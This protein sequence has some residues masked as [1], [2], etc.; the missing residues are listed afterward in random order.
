MAQGVNLNRNN[1]SVIAHRYSALSEKVGL[2]LLPLVGLTAGWL[3]NEMWVHFEFLKF[4]I[5]QTIC[6]LLPLILLQS[7]YS[8]I[9]AFQLV[10][11]N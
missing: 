2:M 3:A 6:I 8:I 9:Y 7:Y 11:L 10:F 4:C 1:R 5:G